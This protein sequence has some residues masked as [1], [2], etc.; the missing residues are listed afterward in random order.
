M[1]ASFLIRAPPRTIEWRGAVSGRG[2]PEETQAKAAPGELPR[3]RL[4]R[5]R[6]PVPLR[7]QAGR[8]RRQEP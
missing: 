7:T 3:K 5:L 1:V 4:P 6:A 2:L 8:R